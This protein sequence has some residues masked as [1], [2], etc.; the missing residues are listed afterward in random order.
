MTPDPEQPDPILPDA[1]GRELRHLSAPPRP[2][3][4]SVDDVVNAALLR[5]PEGRRRRL[6]GFG[7]LASLAAVAALIAWI[8]WPTAPMPP[9]AGP[10]AVA[11]DL[12]ASGT[13][14]VADVLTL[15][16]LA[17]QGGQPD[18]FTDIDG[19]GHLTASDPRALARILVT[20]A[21]ASVPGPA[22]RHEIPTDAADFLTWDVL[23]DTGGPELGAWQV[24]LKAHGL[25]LVGIEGGDPP[26]ADPPVYDAAA[27][28]EGEVA[29]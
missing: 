13:F 7:A 5:L 10:P 15:A 17:E 25:T 6:P 16:R 27:L 26:F 8:V 4:D 1:L 20:A 19:D 28:A 29:L 9:V 21:L 14:D 23:I 2:M 12:N 22:D 11:H 18:S 3:P 24:Q